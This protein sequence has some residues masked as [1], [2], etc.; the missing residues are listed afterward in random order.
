MI[1]KL[2]AHVAL[3]LAPYMHVGTCTIARGTPL[4]LWARCRPTVGEHRHQRGN[5]AA[6][7]KLAAS[8]HVASTQVAKC[9]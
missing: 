9:L 4:P 1:G 8:Q 5:P 6:S 2:G 3:A 7:N